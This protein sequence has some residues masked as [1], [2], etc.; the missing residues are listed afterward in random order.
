MWYSTLH[1]WTGDRQA[2]NVLLDEHLSWMRD[3]QR[4]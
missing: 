2:A 3:Q 1:S 4:G